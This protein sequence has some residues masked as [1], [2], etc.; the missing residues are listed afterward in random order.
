MRG[1]CQSPVHVPSVWC[2]S[3]TTFP[4]SSYRIRHPVESEKKNV[5]E[6]G[7]EDSCVI[8]VCGGEVT[9]SERGEEEGSWET[10]RLEK[11]TEQMMVDFRVPAHACP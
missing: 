9:I 1:V 7:E 2:R 8:C 11:G 10:P 6:C 3:S 4:L 5:G